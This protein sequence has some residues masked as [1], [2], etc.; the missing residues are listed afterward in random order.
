MF[1]LE[2]CW[3]PKAL[4]EMERVHPFIDMRE[5]EANDSTGRCANQSSDV[6]F[7]TVIDYIYTLLNPNQLRK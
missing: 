2:N 1:R 4:N 7:L 6:N 5:D 3:S